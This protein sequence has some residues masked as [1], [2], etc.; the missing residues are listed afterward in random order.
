MTV[1]FGW[2]PPDFVMELA[3]GGDFVFTLQANQNWPTGIG[4]ELRLYRT[5]DPSGDLNPIIW[6]ATIVGANASWDVSATQVTNAI[7]QRAL[8]P[9]L[10]YSELDGSTLVWMRGI[11]NAS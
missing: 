7:T 1:A 2:K 5:P 4:I 8:Y 6:P 11:V 9:R 3:W 10:R